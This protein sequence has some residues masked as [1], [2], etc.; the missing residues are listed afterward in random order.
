[1]S[2]RVTIKS[3]AR[4]LGISHMTVSR[5]LSGHPSVLKET[6][7]AVQN[8]ARELGYVKHAAANVMRGQ[9]T[10]IVGL[11]LPNIVNEF[12]ARFANT[13]ALACEAQSLQ[14]IIHLTGDEAGAER[15]ALARLNEVQAQGVVM[16]PV[17][18][19]DG[20]MTLKP[21]PMSVVQLIRQSGADAAP[22]ILVDDDQALQGAVA[23]LAEKGHRAIAYIGADSRLSSGQSRLASFR[24]GLERAGVA[25]RPELLFTGT[26]TAEIGAQRMRQVLGDGAATALVCG[27]VEISNGALSAMMAAGVSPTGP[28]DLVGYGDPSFYAWIGGGL[29]TIG[30]P[31]ERLAHK[32]VELMVAASPP[33]R[34]HRFEAALIVRPGSPPG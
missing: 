21:R 26:P 20:A 5:A 7:E 1:M 28:F 30:V 10:R 4:D 19:S 2:E 14:L 12:Y 31:V 15:Q 33:P 27:G 24:A 23:H 17:P 13:M 3:I 29:T 8:R 22:T 25:E 16:V 6:R 32:A 9:T 34:I 18:G 11:L